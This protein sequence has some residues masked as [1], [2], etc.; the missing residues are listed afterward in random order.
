MARDMDHRLLVG[1]QAHAPARQRILDAPDGQFVAGNLAAGKHHCVTRFKLDRMRIP[2]DPRQRR[3]RFALAARGHDQ[4]F[5]AR[6]V[7]RPVHRYAIGEILQIS[8]GLGR[9]DDPVERTPGHDQPPPGLPGNPGQRLQ[10][11]DVRGKGG[12]DH[13]APLEPGHRL[14]QAVAHRAFGARGAR[15]ENIGRIA[16]QRQNARIADCGQFRRRRRFADLR[17]VIQ[18]PVTGVEHPAIGRVDDQRVAFGDR[19]R[20]RHITNGKGPQRQRSVVLDH[21]QFDLFVDPRLNQLFM[22]QARGKRRGIQRH[23]QIGGEIGHR[24]DMILVRMGQ[25]DPEQVFRPF[26]DKFQIGKHQID[27]RVPRVGK[28]HPQIDHQ[29]FA[30]TTIKVDVHSDFARATERAE[31]QFLTRLHVNS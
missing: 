16:H 31:Q 17:R 12:H 6:Q 1:D 25:H 20:Q 11:R 21:A 27:T 15:I 22:H 26:L 18:F 19:M 29:P 3:A 8:A 24:A 28:G 30:V 13:A 10:P 4:H 7:H 9:A 5:A 23:A 14:Q 2:R